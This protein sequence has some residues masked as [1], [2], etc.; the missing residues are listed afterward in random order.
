MENDC[1]PVMRLC[2]VMCYMAESPQKAA[3]V[4]KYDNHYIDGPMVCVT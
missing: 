2:D 3:D 4:A 1:L